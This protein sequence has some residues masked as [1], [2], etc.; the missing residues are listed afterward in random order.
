MVH[1]EL[2][3]SSSPRQNSADEGE[4]RRCRRCISV[5]VGSG[6]L[7]RREE[8]VLSLYGMMLKSGVGDEGRG[9]RGSD[10]CSCAHC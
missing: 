6:E 9:I 1:K 4:G 7:E 3:M 10:L 8:K 5:R 2:D